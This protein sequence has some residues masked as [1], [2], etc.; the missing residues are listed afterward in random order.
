MGY[1]EKVIDPCI[2]KLRIGFPKGIS[3]V[4]NLPVPLYLSHHARNKIG[5]RTYGPSLVYFIYKLHDFLI[6]RV[7]YS[8][9]I[10]HSYIIIRMFLDQESNS[11]SSLYTHKKCTEEI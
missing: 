1:G 7:I 9:A 10:L 5:L 4:T 8:Y 3:Q 11:Q 6:I 2:M